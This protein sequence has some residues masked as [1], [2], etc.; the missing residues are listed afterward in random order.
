MDLE[1]PVIV[2][3]STQGSTVG[4]TKV[5]KSEDLSDALNTA[6]QYSSEVIIEK[7]IQGKEITVGI[8][9]NTVL[10]IIEIVP[11]KSFYDYEAKYVSGMSSHILPAVL[12]ETTYKQAQAYAKR[13]YSI[14]NCCGA[15]R[16][17]MIVGNDEKI[18]VLEI[19]TIPGM[20]PTSLLPEA[21]R[22]AGIS[23]NQLVLKIIEL[24]VAERQLRN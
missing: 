24:S 17:D 11:K 5:L 1:F 3:P 6:F 7:Y 2:K 20:T 19:N 21:A 12:A 15:V 10:P 14:F 22:E 23:F 16:V 9:G 4:I 13:V 18:Y 8:L